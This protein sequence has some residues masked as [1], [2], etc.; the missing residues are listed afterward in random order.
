MGEK[1]LWSFI[2][3]ISLEVYFKSTPIVKL[4]FKSESIIYRAPIVNDCA[5]PKP[6]NFFD[7]CRAVKR[8]IH[9][10]IYNLYTSYQTI[11]KSKIDS[12]I[13]RIF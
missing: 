7:L 3:L 12:M 9:K 2:F 8:H 6:L 1:L 5:G 11:V 10:Y 13:T 4:L